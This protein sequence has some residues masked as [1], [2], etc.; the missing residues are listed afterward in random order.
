MVSRNRVGKKQE[1]PREA[2]P[3]PTAFRGASWPLVPGPLVHS[4]GGP[5]PHTSGSPQ[6]VLLLWAGHVQRETDNR[7]VLRSWGQRRLPGGAQSGRMSRHEADVSPRN[8]GHD[9]LCV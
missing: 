7:R 8:V 9:C 3:S 1:E 6:T 5:C 2:P 4:A